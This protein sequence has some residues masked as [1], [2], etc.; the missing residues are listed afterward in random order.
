MAES[1]I[2][3]ISLNENGMDSK[4]NGMDADIHLCSFKDS[5]ISLFFDSIL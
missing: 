1:C 5:L 4:H 2:E 3:Y